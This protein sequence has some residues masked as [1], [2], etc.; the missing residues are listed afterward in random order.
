MSPFDRPHPINNK[1]FKTV[2][3][4][5]K[6]AKKELH[7]TTKEGGPSTSEIEAIGKTLKSIF[8]WKCPHC[9]YPEDT[10]KILFLVL[11]FL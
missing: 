1:Y 9:S 3:L 11:L 5:T 8:K 4:M 10:K 7:L 2:Y 6:L